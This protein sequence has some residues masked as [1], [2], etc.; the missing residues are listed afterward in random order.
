[1]LTTR[2]ST[3]LQLPRGEGRAAGRVG[4]EAWGW[5]GSVRRESQHLPSSSVIFRH[6]RYSSAL[7][8]NLFSLGE[9]G[10]EEWG[11]NGG[12][13]G[14]VKMKAWRW[15]DVEGSVVSLRT[16]MI[17]NDINMLRV[18]EHAVARGVNCVNTKRNSNKSSRSWQTFEFGPAF[19]VSTSAK[20]TCT[21][22]VRLR[23]FNYAEGRE[24]RESGEGSVGMKA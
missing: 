23:P 8:C 22:H 21:P 13:D 16:A 24:G 15:K 11:V 10:R 14:R 12:G 20:H 3:P 5:N 18:R 9:M 6:A 4:R 1:M 19:S 7:F 2:S 17:S